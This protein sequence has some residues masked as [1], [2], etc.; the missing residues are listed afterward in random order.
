MKEHQFNDQL[1]NK[2]NPLYFY[3]PKWHET[4]ELGNLNLE[5][6]LISEKKDRPIVILGYNPENMIISPGEGTMTETK[7]EGKVANFTRLDVKTGDGRAFQVFILGFEYKTS[8]KSSSNANTN[9]NSNPNNN[10]NNV[11][12]NNEEE[13]LKSHAKI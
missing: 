3:F 4:L 12:T 10:N 9:I 7:L 13:T 8:I 2:I 1:N 6:N 11:K 5:S